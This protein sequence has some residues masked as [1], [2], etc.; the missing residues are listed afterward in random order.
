MKPDKKLH[1]SRMCGKGVGNGFLNIE[2]AG[3]GQSWRYI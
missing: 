3:N 1:Q 2:Q